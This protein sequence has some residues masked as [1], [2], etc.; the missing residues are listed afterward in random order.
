MFEELTRLF[1][2]QTLGSWALL[3]AALILT[4]YLA[5][6]QSHGLVR[7]LTRSAHGMLKAAALGVERAERQ[8]GE[9]NRL[10]RLAQAHREQEARLEREFERVEIAFKRDFSKYPAMHHALAEQVARIDE[11]YQRAADPPPQPPAWLEAIDAVARVP[12][13]DDP[14]II[15][16]L[17]DMHATLEHASHHALI[18]YRVA[19]RKRHK[20]L[21]RLLPYWRRVDATLRDVHNT[22][23]TLEQRI[24]TID[25]QMDAYRELRTSDKASSRILD[26]SALTRF[27][28]A[29]LLLL[30]AGAA[31]VFN[32]D[33][34][35]RGL[36]PLLD[37]GAGPV[38]S[39][40]VTGGF[41]TLLQIG[42]GLIFLEGFRITR[43]LP[44]LESLDELARTRLITAAAGVLLTLT[45]LEASLAFSTAR[46]VLPTLEG[47]AAAGAPKLVGSLMLMLLGTILPLAL[48]LVA[49]PLEAFLNS[50]RN[51][52]GG[53]AVL[54]LR[55]SALLLRLTGTAVKASGSI[56]LRSYDLV[57]FVPLW[58]EG[59]FPRAQ[60]QA[61]D[62]PD[63]E[64]TVEPPP[65]TKRVTK[66]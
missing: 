52:L 45:A 35:S 44:M 3:V 23:Q 60:H 59:L 21:L 18:E 38:S 11:D 14:A 61:D 5:R 20:G 9:R 66:A 37:G 36:A 39:A 29:S 49:I 6:Q 65:T 42:A 34:L 17:G 30:L 4:L 16:I 62:E 28:V 33:L 64:L 10:V 63:S 46:D 48:A 50:A 13:H 24:T 19:S 2:P 27:A 26:A 32:H 8:L 31:A 1:P 58:I 54:L 53:I 51:V 43:M 47:E 55:G 7:T 40:S 41:I 12:H 15:R 25:Q 56:L 22:V 57:I